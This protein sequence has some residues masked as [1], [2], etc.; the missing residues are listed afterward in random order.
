MHTIY[1]DIL[2]F[3]NLVID[4]LILDIT[5]VILSVNV[6]YKKIFIGSI[7][8]S[9]FSLIIFLPNLFPILNFL[10]NITISAL[11]ILLTYGRCT[12]N[13]FIK[14]LICY[15]GINIIFAG[16][17]TAIFS[18]NKYENIIVNNGTFY[19][20]ISPILLIILTLICYIILYIGKRIL[21]KQIIAEKICNITAVLDGN[22][23]IFNAKVDTGCDLREPFSNKP[24]IIAEITIFS[25][26][27]LNNKQFRLVPFNSLGGEGILK[28]IKLDKLFIDNTLINKEIYVGFCENILKGDVKALISNDIIGDE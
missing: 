16:I 21:G 1:I 17:I 9:L 6:K 3:I 12:L 20:D 11:I 22:S 28:A 18:I 13:T 8:S 4:F 15:I 23:Y 24:V 14:R 26:L 19:F 5:K 27:N 7:V 10:I 2:L 25:T